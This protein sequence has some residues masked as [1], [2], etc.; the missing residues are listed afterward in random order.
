MRLQPAAGNT[1]MRQL[2]SVSRPVI[3]PALLISCML[4]LLPHTGFADELDEQLK[5]FVVQAKGP[6]APSTIAALAQSAKPTTLDP[7]S[8][9]DA[10]KFSAQEVIKVL[11]G[12]YQ[13]TYWSETLRSNPQLKLFLDKPLGDLVY[14]IQ[15][16]A[17]VYVAKR[18]DPPFHYAVKA[19]ENAADIFKGLTGSAGSRSEI[20]RFFQKSDV[21]NIASIKPGQVLAFAQYTRPTVVQIDTQNTAAVTVDPTALK[22]TNAA[23]VL[24][25]VAP[26]PPTSAPDT[27]P[28]LQIAAGRISA[29]VTNGYQP[30]EEC[31]S[32]KPTIPFDPLQLKNA[33]AYSLKEAVNDLNI[34]QYPALVTIADNGFFGARL[35]GSKPV[36]GAPFPAR[37]FGTS[38]QYSDGQIGP[39]V[40]DG[41]QPIYPLNYS[42]HLTTADIVSG[43]GTHITGLVLGGP[44]FKTLTSLFDNDAGQPWLHLL[45]INVGRGEETLTP[46]SEQQLITMI[47]MLD[48]RIVNLSIEYKN[49]AYGNIRNTFT[50]MVTGAHSGN[51]LYVVS[52]GNDS[53]TDVGASG[54]YPAA[55]G[56][57]A[58]PNVI[59]VAAHRNDGSLA[60]FG[61]RGPNTV[62]IAAPG[63]N[64]SSWI[65][66]VDVPYQVS[67]T[68]QAAAIVTFL[69]SLIRSLGDFSPAQIKQRIFVSGDP[70]SNGHFSTQNSYVGELNP[71]PAEIMSRS[72]INPVKALF[73]YDDYVRYR[74]PG[75]TADREV[76]GEVDQVPVITCEGVAA[77]SSDGKD[78]WAFKTDGYPR[79]GWL[80]RGRATAMLSRPC[81]A[82]ISGDQP[83]HIKP[84]ATLDAAGNLS[85]ANPADALTITPDAVREFVAATN[86][87]TQ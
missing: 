34:G 35:V 87:Q 55:L 10:P 75:E 2:T 13:S 56:G 72:K 51:N 64:I 74:L 9:P 17:C 7:A 21:K 48:S 50:D 8:Y 52:A 77:D 19:G 42:N 67:G 46:D 63:C 25:V 22:F 28:H 15:W 31:T 45:I 54:Y 37:F 70:L 58:Q 41:T 27:R 61:N 71:D 18:V 11:C 36:F 66:E 53:A 78:T 79:A 29:A 80:Y 82:K 6:V 44:I 1:T 65:N 26:P 43:H 39:V 85:A 47:R 57:G 83:L 49:N 76:I 33:Y 62:D 40:K 84:H 69:A 68:S 73:V 5:N 86:L 20:G 81:Q 16:P 12:S 3:R 38:R 32:D 14:K 23:D 60:N 59:S 30:P 24:P 4:I